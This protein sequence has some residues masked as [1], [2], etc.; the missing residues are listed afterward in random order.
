MSQVAQETTCLHC[1][2]PLDGEG[3]EVRVRGEN[4]KVCSKACLDAVGRIDQLDL[5]EYY[6][7]RD[8]F[9]AGQVAPDVM[10][11]KT[12]SRARNRELEFEDCATRRRGTTRLTVRVPDIRCAAC[13][14]LIEKSLRQREDVTDVRTNLADRRVTIEFDGTDV[15]EMVAFIEA[16]GF[17]VLPDRVSE[18]TRAL[19]KERKSMLARMGVAGIGMMQVM[20]YAIATYVAGPGGIEPAYETLMHWASLAL[21][22]PIVIYSAGPFHHGA[23]RDLQHGNLGMDV[24]VSLAVLAAFG[25]SLINT[26]R[27][28]GE[29]Y[30][31]SATMFT[32]LLLIGRYIELGSRRK[33]QSSQMLTDSLLPSSAVMA[34]DEQHIPVQNI[35][36][37]DIVVVM[38]GQPVTVDGLIVHGKTSV[39]ESAFTGESKPVEKSVGDRVLAGADNLD[40]EILVRASVPYREF[41][42]TRISEL[43]RES[44]S[45][46][47]RFSMI[48]DRVARYFVGFILVA[49]TLSAA[50]WYF[51]GSGE[52]FSIGLA[53]LVVSCPCALSL[54]TPVAYTVAISTMRTNGIVIGNGTFLER[55]AGITRVVFDK[56][57]TL[58][59]GALKL[60][61]VVPL[62]AMSRSEALDIAAALE[63]HSQH[64]I[65]RAFVSNAALHAREVHV[66]PG[67][68]VC[69]EVG[70][71][72]YRIGKPGFAM[73][74]PPFVPSEVGTWVLLA[75]E[76]PIAWFCLA[77]EVRDEAA[78]VVAGLLE[79]FGVSLYTGDVAEEGRKLGVLLGIEDVITGMTPEDK[80]RQTRALQDRGE[81]ILMVGDGINDAAAL[82]SASASIAVSPAD[83]VVQ[84]AADATLLKANLDRIPVAIN[85]ASRVQRVIRQNIAWA[86]AYNL[87]V[88]PLAMAGVIL[89]WMAALGMSASSVLVVLNANRLRKVT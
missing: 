86:I 25:L 13:T 64:P 53:V 66:V 79:R 75:S 58:T 45:Y 82:A 30:F 42:I 1:L 49:A 84:E 65:A 43:Y 40:G 22:T 47:P 27:G 77:D 8:R 34:H 5:A 12:P 11:E 21:A 76:V 52:W 78:D 24:P 44:S 80:V 31:D 62:A 70:G 74:A 33:Y 46:K 67:E 23:W 7:Y 68:G 54:A 14:W 48:A 81:R 73:D 35:V 36:A 83:I 18:A 59:R 51:A 87:I 38:P 32:F 26:L 20:M 10:P 41:V 61:K 37:G 69:G 3:F 28:S 72:T 15:M 16:L 9:S 89:P 2:R 56:T 60:E 19:D 63:A 57:G 6:S 39:V 88:I 29:V 17:S 85:F 55:L 50:G 71:T 4:H